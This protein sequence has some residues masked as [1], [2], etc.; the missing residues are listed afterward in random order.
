MV[1]WASKWSVMVRRTV[2]VDAGQSEIELR[3]SDRRQWC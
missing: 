1:W 2:Q 3:R